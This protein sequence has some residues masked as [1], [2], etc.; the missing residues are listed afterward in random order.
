MNL[1]QAN[2]RRFLNPPIVEAIIG[3]SIRELPDS[4]LEVI[5]A[6][7]GTL[8]QMDYTLEAPM[9][10][11]SVTWEI[12][13][14]ASRADKLDQLTGY[15]FFSSDR[16]FAFQFLRSGMVFSQ[17]GRYESWETF[18][19]E[20]KRIWNV[21]ESAFG[22]LQLVHY[23]VRYINKVFVPVGQPTEDFIRL[24]IDVPLELPQ[25]IY[26]PYLRVIFKIENPQGVLTHQQ[27][28]F[29]PER[30]GFTATLL[31]N[32]FVFP[33]SDVTIESLWSAIDSVREIKDHFFLGML[34]ERMKETF[35]A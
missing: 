17:L 15:Q 20:A 25:E 4:A 21:Y 26:E 32:D 31:D 19:A 10:S 30:D 18:T 22:D 29:P 9:T 33:A 27:G 28:L 11:H 2:N 1:A 23:R 14:G 24:Y 13:D 16:S 34:T 6:L 7:S 12:A 5:R 3:I 8:A 35:D